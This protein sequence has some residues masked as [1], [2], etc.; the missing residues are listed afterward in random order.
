M[1]C[2]FCNSKNCSEIYTPFGSKIELKIIICM[3]C[4][5]VQSKTSDIVH[6]EKNE[7]FSQL[8]CDADY[9]AIRVGK[10]QMAKYAFFCL[11][12][13]KEEFQPKEILDMCS[14]RGHFAKKAIDFFNLNTIDCIEPDEYMTKD[15]QNDKKINLWIGKYYKFN[16]PK[17]YD[18]VYSCHTLEHFRDPSKNIFYMCNKTKMGGRIFLDVPN[19]LSIDK[20]YHFDE[21]FYDKHLFYFNKKLLVCFFEINGFIME[22]DFSTKSSIVL[23]F[24]KIEE[25]KEKKLTKKY[26]EIVEKN[27]LMVTKYKN[28]L[29]KSRKHIP[30]IVKNI[31]SKANEKKSAI[32][33]C[34]RILNALVEYGGLDTEK[35]DV[36]IDN[37]LAEVTK[38]LY[39]KS[40]NKIDILNKT[41]IEIFFLMTS[42]ATNELKKLL[43]TNNK[44]SIIYHIDD[45]LEEVASKK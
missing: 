27:K 38:E 30:Q 22:R 3:S 35:F 2:N 7:N 10:Q 24:K 34:G 12:Q 36:L 21:F 29:A 39:G 45:I 13:I 25:C 4:G 5:L 26:P 43:K 18:L 15:Y 44:N 1:E 16:S 28:N 37:Y 17:K 6:Q 40:L 42:S 20:K 23:I 32:I 41:E 14:A 33:G 19:L 31:Y 9:S 11:E 8:S